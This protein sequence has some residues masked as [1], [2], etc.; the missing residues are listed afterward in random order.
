MIAIP[1]GSDMPLFLSFL[2]I[3]LHTTHTTLSFGYYEIYIDDT[4]LLSATKIK[5]KI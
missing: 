5:I 3:Q 4:V 1:V 2:K